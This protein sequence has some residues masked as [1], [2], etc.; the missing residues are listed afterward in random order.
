M[1]IAD[2]YRD[3]LKCNCSGNYEIDDNRFICNS[4]SHE[5]KFNNSYICLFDN[6]D[7]RPFWSIHM[8]TMFRKHGIVLEMDSKYNAFDKYYSKKEVVL[9]FFDRILDNGKIIID[10]ASG[11]S[12]YFGT[13]IKK[14]RDD[15]L[16]IISD[17]SPDILKAHMEANKEKNNIGYM[18][19]DL[20]KPLPFKNDSIDNFMGNYLGNVM[21]Y[22]Q[23]VS[24]AYRSLKN[25]GRFSVIEIFYEQGSETAFELR[26]E[27]RLYADL[28]KYIQYFESVGFK[29]ECKGTIEHVVGKLDPSDSL[30]RNDTDKSE[31]IAFSFYK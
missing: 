13:I 20:D 24:E 17:G 9:D 30:P 5:I 25:G 23:L 21:E 11:P 7:E 22:Q 10:L 1:R 18:D 15:Q 27:N 2:T 8:Q 19:L 31:I 16:F 14:L 3:I 6:E 4:C 29:L 12:G 26:R 28:D